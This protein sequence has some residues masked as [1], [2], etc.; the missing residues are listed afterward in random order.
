MIPEN[1]PDG[2]FPPAVEQEYFQ[3]N[4]TNHQKENLNSWLYDPTLIE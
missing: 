4:K 3:E 2:P 1:P